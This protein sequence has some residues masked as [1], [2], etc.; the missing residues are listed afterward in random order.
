ML[1]PLPPRVVAEP[2]APQYDP[3]DRDKDITEV[4]DKYSIFR[5]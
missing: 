4:K 5:L 1:S 3:L 2:I